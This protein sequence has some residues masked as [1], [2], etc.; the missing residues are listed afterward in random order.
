MSPTGPQGPGDLAGVALLCA[1]LGTRLRP[2]TEHCAKPAVKVAGRPMIHHLLDELTPLHGLPFALNSH[3]APQTLE[4]AVGDYRTGGGSG[5]DNIKVHHEPTL[6]GSGGGLFHLSGKLPDGWLLA[7][8]GDALL[9]VDWD[10]MFAQTADLQQNE[11]AWLVTEPQRGRLSG[12]VIKEGAIRSIRPAG[13]AELPAFT[14]MALLGPA[15][16]Q[17]FPD[18]E[19]KGVIEALYKK[20]MGEGK[21]KAVT[22]VRS[23]LDLGTP[24]DLK[25]AESILLAR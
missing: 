23:F 12:L 9:Q 6:L 13:E 17:A 11:A 24:E 25:E 20:L 21:L 4:Q 14:G 18:P 3:H 7:A 16:R 10:V 1:G 15:L 22:G 2:L 5:L 8:N 19:P